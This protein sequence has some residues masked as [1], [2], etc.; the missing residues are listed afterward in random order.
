MNECTPASVEGF[1]EFEILWARITCE[2]VRDRLYRREDGDGG[3]HC[4]ADDGKV[5]EG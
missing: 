5:T 1:G 4:G 2:S 3:C